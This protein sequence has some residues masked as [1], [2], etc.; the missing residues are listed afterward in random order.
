MTIELPDPQ[1]CDCGYRVKWFVPCE[2]EEDLPD[3]FTSDYRME[4]DVVERSCPHRN[5][6]ML[7]HCPA[8]DCQV[9]IWGCGMAGTMECACWDTWDTPSWWQRLKRRVRAIVGV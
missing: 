5:G 8:C 4:T 1:H 9:G 6:T 3:W 7:E 2:P